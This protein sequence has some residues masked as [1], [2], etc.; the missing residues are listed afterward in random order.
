MRVLCHLSSPACT[1]GACKCGITLCSRPLIPWAEKGASSIKLHKRTKDTLTS[2]VLLSEESPRHTQAE[3]R[4]QSRC[5]CS[6]CILSVSICGCALWAGSKE[7]DP[8]QSISL[9]GQH[10]RSPLM[11]QHK[12]GLTSDYISSTLQCGKREVFFLIFVLTI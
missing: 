6:V 11:T 7:D 12:I 9:L 3:K 1:G 5:L 2:F 8:T 10:R 4:K